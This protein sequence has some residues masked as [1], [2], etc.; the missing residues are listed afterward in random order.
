MADSPAAV[1]GLDVP[2]RA[3][4]VRELQ[5]R[6][7]QVVVADRRVAGTV[8]SQRDVL[9]DSPV[10]VD[11][12]DVPGCAVPVRVLQIP[13]ADNGGSTE[14]HALL[15]GGPAIDAGNPAGCTDEAGM[16]LLTDQRGEP[17]PFGPACDIGA[18][19]AGSCVDTIPPNQGNVIL[20]FK[21][22]TDVVLDF[23]GAPATMWRVYRDA[24]KTV[25]G[26]TGLTPD[27]GVTVFTDGGAVP[28]TAGE[29]LFYYLKGLS[30]CSLTPGP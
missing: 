12:L 18:F 5:V 28:M 17:R 15:T 21:S 11:S 4:P 16:P 25:I 23:T 19:E 24:D 2:R 26:A 22:D 7:R 20:A 10:A 13:L 1:D 27:V 3:V 29:K 6:V 8:K 14:T 9:A 30:P